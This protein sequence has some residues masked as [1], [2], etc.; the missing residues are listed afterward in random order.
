MK[1]LGAAIT[2]YLFGE[3]CLIAPV[4]CR[5]CF[6]VW[7]RRSLCAIMIVPRSTGFVVLMTLLITVAVAMIVV[8]IC[9]M[10]LFISIIPPCFCAIC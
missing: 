3:L 6:V 4:T 5:C 7:H 1:R 9:H 8:T 10:S 2:L